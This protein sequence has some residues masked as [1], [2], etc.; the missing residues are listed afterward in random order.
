M[1]KTKTSKKTTKVDMLSLMRESKKKNSKK[2]AKPQKMGYLNIGERQQV[3]LLKNLGY[4]E[5]DIAVALGC[6]ERTV[7]RTLKRFR[8]TGNL[9]NKPKIGR[10]RKT[11]PAV[12]REIAFLVEQDR[13]RTSTQLVAMLKDKYPDVQISASTV[14]RR[15]ISLGLFGRMASRK[16]LLREANKL[17]RLAFAEKYQHW[18][19]A[20][21][22]KVL[23][24]DEKKFELF[25][26]KRRLYVRRK[27]REPLRNDTIQPTVKHGG[28][29]VMVWGCFMGTKVGDLYRINGI[30]NKEQYHQILV[31]HA[32]PS[33]K[34][35]G[36]QGFVFQQDNDPKHTSLMVKNYLQKKERE[37]TITLLED[38]PSQSPDINAI[39]L[40]WEEMDRQVQK[41]RPTNEQALLAIVNQVWNNLQPE[42]LQKYIDRLPRVMK[43]IIEA[44]GG[45][46][47]EKYDVRK[48]KLQPVYK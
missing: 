33:G 29:S 42:V 22:A 7:W 24:S 18:T 28:G 2:Q 40:L 6:G 12:D 47:D 30:M 37:G 15:L 13:S 14:R 41:E 46:F 39:E 4:S 17:K 5:P 9:T 25:N 1:T 20:D 43:A 16:P 8:E 48:F 26:S 21:W 35:L 19:A 44:Q 23:W 36:G 27:I 3:L 45:Y 34:R 38:W 32:I 11:T 31:H 10:S